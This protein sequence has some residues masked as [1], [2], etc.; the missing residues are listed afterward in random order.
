MTEAVPIHPGDK[1]LLALSLGHL[2]EAELAHISSHLGH[3]PECCRRI[4]ELNSGDRLVARLQESAASR[5][6]VL[7]TPDEHRSAG[8]VLRR[9]QTARLNATPYHNEEL[10]GGLPG[11][12]TRFLAPAEQP[13]EIGRLG[14]YRIQAVVGK[15]GMGVVFRAHDPALNRLVALK[16][17]LPS[18]AA[19]PTAGMRFLREAKAAAALKHPHVVTVFQ[20]G[21]DRGIPFLAMEYLEGEPLD[22]HIRREGQLPLADALRIGRE[23]ALGLAAAHTRGLVH[24]DIKPANLWLERPAGHVKILDF[25]LAHALANEAELTQLG[26]IVGTPAYMAPEQADGMPVDTRCDLFSL[27]CVLYQMVTGTLPYQG[28]TTMAI[29]HALAVHEPPPVCALRP[30]AP[31]EL[32][33]LVTRL[34]ARNPEDRPA[35]AQE[36]AETLTAVER[37]PPAPAAPEPAAMPLPRSRK[38]HILA[39][40]AA[41]AAALALTRVLWPTPPS[42]VGIE[43]DAPAATVPETYTNSLGM[44]FV[45]IPKGKAWL[46]GGEGRRGT[47]TAEI[48]DDFYLGRYE[49]TQQQWMQIMRTNPSYFSRSGEG[50]ASIAL[51]SDDELKRF[52]VE[53]VTKGAAEQFLKKLNQQEHDP[54]WIYRLPTSV[55]WEYACRGGP[56]GNPA[57]SAF[58]FYFALGTNLIQP[59][60]ANVPDVNSLARTC[61]VGSYQ[62]NRL[63]LYDMHGNV[64]EFC[65]ENIQQPDGHWEVMARGGGNHGYAEE[66][67]A[68]SV[69]NLMPWQRAL[70][71]GLRV[72]RVQRPA[73]PADVSRDEQPARDALRPPPLARAPFDTRQASAHQEAWA[74]YL[75]GSVLTENSLGMKFRLIPPGEFTMGLSD[76]EEHAS[77]T[78][79]ED[80]TRAHRAV[81]AHSVRLTRPF[82]MSQRDLRHHE[83]VGVLRR[84]PGHEPRDTRNQNYAPLRARCTWFDCIEFCNRL[85][86]QEELTPAYTIE[87]RAVTLIPDATGYRLPTEAEWEFACRA[88][89]TSL[90]Y[91]GLTAEDAQTMFARS[92]SEA[93]GYLRARIGSSNPFGLIGMYTGS[94]EWCWDRYS[95]GYYGDCKA[96]GVAVDPL[97]PDEGSERVTRGGMYDADRDLATRNSAARHPSNPQ[98]PSDAIGFGR[99]VLPFPAPGQTSWVRP[100]PHH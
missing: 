68:R 81:P 55:E 30:E 70:Q 44:E 53:C 58:D 51:V 6:A 33:S 92:R 15:G 14:S 21:E 9:W 79:S 22:D 29:L 80:T 32:S 56:M 76:A 89:T 66:C 47:E 63:G 62:P 27:G 16:A 73:R 93:Q 50:N 86:E 4:D 57:E 98:K 2:G 69:A 11:D 40:G 25:G 45:R 85:S 24:R 48:N 67:R 28:A 8:R 42:T 36:V 12:V 100:A 72:A 1:L 52:P 74:R 90:W 95:S 17:L 78:I 26:M 41:L 99:C 35:S 64:Q 34:L 5:D 91:F 77:S 71:V 96:R 31:A 23:T 65:Y 20:V 75:G 39:A 43:R 37:L 82:Y 13:D 54:G 60:Q 18:M 84:E 61:R 97:G 83:F 87:G 46:G 7:G 19:V 59:S 49:V 3:C 94:S 88:G 38:P 10:S